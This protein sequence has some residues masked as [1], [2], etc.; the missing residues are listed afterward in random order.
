MCVRAWVCVSVCVGEEE[1]NMTIFLSA[2]KKYNK[3][4]TWAAAEMKEWVEKQ[5]NLQS[6]GQSLRTERTGGRIL[7]FLFLFYIGRK[8]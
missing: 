3:Q 7:Y 8:R 2:V 6:P 5:Q 1:E 4:E